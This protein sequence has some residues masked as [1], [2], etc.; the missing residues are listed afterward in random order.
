M[1]FFFL[2]AYSKMLRTFQSR[3][4]FL[5]GVPGL[6]V[7]VPSVFPCLWLGSFISL[8]LSIFGITSLVSLARVCW[9]HKLVCGEQKLSHLRDGATR[10]ATVPAVV[11]RDLHLK[12]VPQPKVGI[13]SKYND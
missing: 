7:T 8:L 12:I 10:P 3:S 13:Q 2:F 5:G 11:E 1:K 4:D 6:I 9:R